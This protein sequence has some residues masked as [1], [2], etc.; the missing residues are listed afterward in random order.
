LHPAGFKHGFQGYSTIV[1]SVHDLTGC[2]SAKDAANIPALEVNG[3]DGF[4]GSAIF[5]PGPVLWNTIIASNMKNPF[6]LIPIISCTA[7]SFDE[8]HE[9][10]ATAV[11]HAEKT[12][13]L[14][15]RHEGRLSSQDKVLR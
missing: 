10:K 5:I 1:P 11:T 12:Q 7:R 13:C 4:E 3:L 9:L 14:A 8:E 15:V 6:K 2:K